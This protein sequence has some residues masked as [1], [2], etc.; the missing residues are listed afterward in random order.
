MKSNSIF[1]KTKTFRI[2]QELDVIQIPNIGVNLEK[3]GDLLYHEG[4]LLS[5]FRDKVQLSEFYLFKWADC[6]ENCNRWLV[7]KSSSESLR[8]FL[9]K[10]YSLLQLVDKNP[11]VFLIDIDEDLNHVR[12]YIA[13]TSSLPPVYLPSANSFFNED[14]YSEIAKSMKV[15]IVKP[16]TRTILAGIE[17]MFAEIKRDQ[18]KMWKSIEIILDTSRLNISRKISDRESNLNMGTN[19][20]QFQN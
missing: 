14:S 6:D 20:V 18:Q 4:P 5:L 1:S 17:T 9:Y 12:Q 7:F 8:G 11:F 2:M 3:V 16:S 19:A 15:E 10:E 13:N